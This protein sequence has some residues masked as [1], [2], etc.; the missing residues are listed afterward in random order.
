MAFWA[1]SNSGAAG[2]GKRA[3]TKPLVNVLLQSLLDVVNRSRACRTQ[4]LA[5]PPDMHASCNQGGRLA[6]RAVLLCNC[7]SANR[8]TFFHSVLEAWER[9]S[10]WPLI[11]PGLWTLYLALNLWGII[12]YG[13]PPELR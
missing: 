2:I 7:G 6:R 4:L 3:I 9:R 1:S 10:I 5:Q 13:E 11:L 12:S 8:F